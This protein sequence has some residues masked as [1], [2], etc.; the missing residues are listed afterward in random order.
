MIS[1][2]EVRR[3]LGNLDDGKVAE[4]VEL[5][6]ARAEVELAATCLAGR[7]YML[8]RSGRHLSAM[9][10]QIIKIVLSDQE[11]LETGR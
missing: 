11:V 2:A 8:A 5:Q 9:A 7:M 4:I 3:L 10:A 1:H 6:P